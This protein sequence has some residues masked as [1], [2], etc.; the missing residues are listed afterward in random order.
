[1]RTQL[2]RPRKGTSRLDEPIPYDMSAVWL[3]GLQRVCET[4][5]VDQLPSGYVYGDDYYCEEHRPE[6]FTRDFRILEAQ[7]KEDDSPF[8]AWDCYWTTWEMVGEDA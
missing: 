3:E 8:Q 2:G 1:M 4:C 5:G 6:H 7:Q